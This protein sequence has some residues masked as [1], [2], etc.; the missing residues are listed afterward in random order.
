MSK[1]NEKP[2]KPSSLAFRIRVGIL[3]VI[4]FCALSQVGRL[5]RY[6]IREG[7]LRSHC[8]DPEMLH[9]LL[10]D[11]SDPGATIAQIW[12]TQKL[13]HRWEVINYLNRN[14]GQRPGLVSDIGGIVEEAANDPDLT[15]RLTALNL[16]RLIG[17]PNWQSAAVTALNDPDPAAREI[18]H[19]VLQRGGVTNK[20]PAKIAMPSPLPRGPGFGQLTFNDFK[21]Q[22]YPLSQFSGRPVLLHFF[23]TWSPD[24]VEEIPELVR[25]RNAAPAELAIVGVSVD[26][27][28]GVK[29]DHHSDLG[30]EHHHCES[31]ASVSPDVF[32]SVERHVILK[33]YNYPIVFDTDGVAT[34]QLEGS[35]LPVHVL[36]DSE[37]RLVRRYVGTR[38]SIDHNRIVRELLGF[39][40]IPAST[41]IYTMKQ[42]DLSLDHTL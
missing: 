11:A 27:V 24:C 38:T 20:P 22:P 30:E 29:H 10:R 6:A 36:L 39:R 32:K 40:E 21:L 28:P 34:A 23:A 8:P 16:M 25:L 35:E 5:N 26:A 37:H 7:I 9:S 33:R 2:A 18:A 3:L 17:H 13:P 1:I 12:N 15:L 4:G 31:C 19:K 41:N 14:I 42:G